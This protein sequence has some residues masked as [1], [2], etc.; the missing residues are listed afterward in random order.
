M[1]TLIK[2][3]KV[4]SGEGFRKVDVLIEDGKIVAVGMG[5]S[6]KEAMVIDADGKLVFPGFIDAH[7]HFDL[8]VANT[9]TADDFYTGTKAAIVGGT[10]M[11][12]DFATQN[13]GETLEEALDNWN[14]KANGKCSCDYGF[15]MAISDWNLTT[16]K[17]L[18]KMI[19][20]GISSFKLYMTY[21][22][23]KLDDRELY[24]ALK[25]IKELGGIAGV[26]CENSGIIEA[27]VEEEKEKGNMGVI[28]HPITRPDIVEAEAVSRLLRIA[29]LVD[30]PIIIVHLTCKASLDEVRKARE[31]G[32][33][34][35][36]ETCPQYLLMDDSFYKL[37]DFEGAK[38]VIAP[39]LRKIEN[40]AALWEAIKQNEVQTISTDHCSFTLSQKA[41]G[42]DDFTKIPGGMPGVETRVRLMYTYGVRR[43]RMKLEDMV[44]LLSEN[45]AKLY[46]IYPQKGCIEPGSDADI[47]IYDPSVEE[48]ISKDNQIQN[49]DYAPFE[50]TPVQGKIDKVFLRGNLVVDNGK[51]YREGAGEFVKRD[52]VKIL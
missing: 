42:K 44:R 21:D 25:A 5:I 32:Q 26:H 4:I 39:P 15:H 50:G 19:D 47:V 52:R 3:G 40:Q 10:T 36:I 35:F 11:I 14:H 16:K 34:V 48:T 23:M 27:L 31:R 22:T 17:D 49:V 2:N 37:P 6:Y 9:V 18:K 7:T 41:M 30:T 51:I 8:E 33:Q 12:I 45:P 20:A 29:Q 1:K 46:G 24:Q 13:K 38:Y 28:A 43:G